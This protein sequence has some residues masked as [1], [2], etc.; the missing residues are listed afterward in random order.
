MVD[1]VG[2]EPTTSSMPW[3]RNSSRRLIIKQLATGALV[4]NRY[5][6]RYF[7]PNFQSKSSGCRGRGVHDTP[8]LP[9]E[10]SGLARRVLYSCQNGS[11]WPGRISRPLS[12]RGN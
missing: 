4:T 6:R 8:E 5:I 12:H 1:L 11:E 3:K 7:R 2:I 9:E 10:N